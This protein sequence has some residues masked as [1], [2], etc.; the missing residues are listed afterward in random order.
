MYMFPITHEIYAVAPF[1]LWWAPWRWAL[2]AYWFRSR[3]AAN[4]ISYTEEEIIATN[5]SKAEVIGLIKLLGYP[6]EISN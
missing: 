6:H 2:R 5:I 3:G 1:R 4:Y